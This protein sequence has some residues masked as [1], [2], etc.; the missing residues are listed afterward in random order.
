MSNNDKKR[1]CQC[2][3]CNEVFDI[4]DVVQ[5]EYDLYNIKIQEKRCPYCKD[6]YRLLNDGLYEI[7]RDK[8]ILHN[9]PTSDERTNWLYFN[10]EN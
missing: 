7:N 3:K 4:G 9:P 6:N 10:R 1:V 2:R 5:V 8:W